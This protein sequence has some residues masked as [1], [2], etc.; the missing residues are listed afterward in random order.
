MTNRIIIFVTAKLKDKSTNQLSANRFNEQTPSNP[1]TRLGIFSRL[2]IRHKDIFASSGSILIR[3]IIKMKERSDIHKYSIVNLQYSIPVYPG[4]VLRIRMFINFNRLAWS[5]QG[6]YIPLSFFLYCFHFE[7]F[8]IYHR[9]EVI[10][11]LNESPSN[12][13]AFLSRWRTEQETNR[14]YRILEF[15]IRNNRLYVFSDGIFALRRCQL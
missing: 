11:N 15:G 9:N 2:D 7:F 5:N 10:T 3:I 8:L 14:I 13:L 4:W 1:E 6:D 12:R